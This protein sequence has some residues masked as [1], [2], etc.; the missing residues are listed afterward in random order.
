MSKEPS[1][2]ESSVGAIWEQAVG[3]GERIGKRYRST[4][5]D[6][7]SLSEKQNAIIK[8]LCLQNAFVGGGFGMFGVFG[9][10]G[11]IPSS[12]ALQ[13]YLLQIL[14]FVDIY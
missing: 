5:Y 6:H 11:G 8:S 10:A 13:V 7:L 3:Y 9:A 12:L 2:F 4:Q 14:I 1:L